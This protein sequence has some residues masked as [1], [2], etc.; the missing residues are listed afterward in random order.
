M[1][2][3]RYNCKECKTDF[4]VTGE[5]VDIPKD[6]ACRVCP[7]C[8]NPITWPTHNEPRDFHAFFSERGFP[9]VWATNPPT[10]LKAVTV[11]NY[12]KWY[13]LYFIEPNGNVSKVP[14]EALEKYQRDD[15]P[16]MGDHVF[17]PN[18][19]QRFC[20]YEGHLIDIEALEM[21]IGRWELEYHGVRSR[22]HQELANP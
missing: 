22:Y 20:A 18:V 7:Y 2:L 8:S 16:V 17:N 9:L 13:S 4:F 1:K 15:G 14:F 3:T 10:K 21:I 5:V 19:V 12:M 11:E 6:L